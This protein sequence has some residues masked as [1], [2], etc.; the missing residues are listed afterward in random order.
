MAKTTIFWEHLQKFYFYPQNRFLPVSRKLS[1]FQQK[2]TLFWDHIEKIYFFPKIFFCLD[3]INLKIP[4]KTTMF[5]HHLE[6]IYF[7][8][9]SRFLPLSR[10]LSTFQQKP[11]LFWDHLEKLIFFPKIV[12]CL[13]LVNF[14]ISAKTTTFW[15]LLKKIYFFSKNRFLPLYRKLSTFRQKQRYLRS[16][17]K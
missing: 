13:Y 10:K 2:T 15:H 5:W 4:S 11:T 12:F 14:K 17:W 1:T 6:K 7:F 8:P 9:K 16:P 3:L